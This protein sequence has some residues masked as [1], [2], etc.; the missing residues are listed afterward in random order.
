MNGAESLVRTLVAGGVDVSFSNPGTSEMHFVAALDR[1]EGM[2]CILGLFEGVVTG[3]ADGYG[4]MTGRPA[5]TLLHLGP[6]LANGLANLHNASRAQ[7]PIVNIIGDHATYHK[8]H[9]APL[10]ADIEALARPY[11]KWLRT[12][13]TAA[14]VGSDGAE[15]IA[16]SR[17]APGRIATLILPADTA[18]AEGGVVAPVPEVP[19]PPVPTDAVV[20]RAAVMLRAKIPTG[21]I[22]AGN[23]LHC[24]GLVLAGRIAA[25]TG[26]RLMTPYTFARVERGAGRPIVERIPYVID[27]AVER[28]KEFR[29]LLM[30]GVSPPV[31]FFAYPDKPSLLTPPDC[32]IHTLARPGEDY[33]GALDALAAAMSLQ[34]TPPVLQKTERTEIPSGA[35]S[36]PGLAAVIAALIPEHAIVIDESITSGRNLMPVTKG[37]APH[38]WLANTGGSIGIALPM[39]VGAAVAAPERPVLCLSADGSAMYTLQ[40]LWT[41]ARESL[42]I[43]TVI[44]ANRAYGILLSEYANVGAGNPGRR[45]LDMLQIGRPDLD[46][47]ALAHGM[48]VPGVRVATLDEFAKA[49]RGG[50]GSGGPNLIEVML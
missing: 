34:A 13:A 22:L 25:G 14:E 19:T 23:A 6:G 48:G 47:V 26:A 49:L 45:A 38:D 42:K 15:A 43:T 24:D 12:S 27:L 2:R 30:V 36:L 50:L 5:S 9:D 46:F 11:S 41:I 7:V 31:A 17:S 10:T 29:Q 20:E 8:R 32:A 3:A 44:F 33:V 35:M 16:A 40:A 4:R 28:L 21:I 37:A 39:A 18:W 1:V